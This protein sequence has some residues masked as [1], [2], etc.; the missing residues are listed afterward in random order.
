MTL[1]FIFT[2]ISITGASKVTII[3]LS[4]YIKTRKKIPGRFFL[5]FFLELSRKFSCNKVYDVSLGFFFNLCVV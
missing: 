2:L 5:F 4:K 1:D 3:L